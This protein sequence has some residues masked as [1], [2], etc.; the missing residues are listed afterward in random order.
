MTWMSVAGAAFGFALTVSGIVA[1]TRRKT[2]AAPDG[3]DERP[4]QGKSAVMLG[5][6]WIVL[7]AGVVV[8]SLASESSGGLIGLLRK[9]GRI[10]MGI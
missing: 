10:F 8:A 1:I 2:R 5:A 7:G 4:Y 9:L 3:E 6:L